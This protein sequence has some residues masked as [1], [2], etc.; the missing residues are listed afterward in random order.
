MAGDTWLR[1]IV[2]LA[3]PAT[4]GCASSWKGHCR[5]CG[6]Y[7]SVRA[8]LFVNMLHQLISMEERLAPQVA[9]SSKEGGSKEV[10][11]RYAT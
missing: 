3:W 11:L 7:N 5:R 2:E 10:D 8:Y 1:L 6:K 9:E 4:H